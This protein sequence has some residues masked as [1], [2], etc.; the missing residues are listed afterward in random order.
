MTRVFGINEFYYLLEG[1][2]WTV[3]LSAIAFAGGGL[4]GGVVALCRTAP[5]RLLRTVSAGYIEVFRGTP[6]LMQLFVVHY[7]CALIGYPMN[8]WLSATIAFTLHSSA[9]LGEIWRG[10]IN[11]VPL[12]QTE[13]AVALGLGYWDRMRFVIFAQAA[14]ISLPATIGFLVTLVKG[15]SL[16]SIIGFIDLARSGTVVSNMTFNPLLVYGLVGAMYFAICWPLSL[17]GARWERRLSQ[18]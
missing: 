11:A 15:T 9:F 6:L 16:A 7:Y 12:G 5:Q 1:L 3:L 17:L 18:A 2:K 13:A 10:S 8:P 14:K 4:L